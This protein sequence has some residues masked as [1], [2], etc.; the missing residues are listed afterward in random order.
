MDRIFFEASATR[1]FASDE[2][3]T[4][5]RDRWL[6]RYLRLEAA[7]VFLMFRGTDID[8][9]H[10]VG[11]VA[12]ALDDPALSERYDDIG[13]FPLLRDV[14]R[15]FPAHLHVNLAPEARGAG[16]GSLLVNRFASEASAAGAPGVHVVT[17]ASSRNVGFYKANDFSFEY[18]FDWRQ[19]HLVL[20]GRTLSPPF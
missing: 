15:R 16:L 9:S 5:F 19:A 2:L 12:G 10:L 7:N 3:R 6:G 4:A 11:Y 13:Y 17:S 14:T 1:S 18:P 20:L 8:P